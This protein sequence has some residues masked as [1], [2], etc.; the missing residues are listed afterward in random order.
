MHQI[1]IQ[2]QQRGPTIS[3]HLYGHFAEHLGRCVYGGFYV[4]EDSDIP[5]VRGIR[6]DIIE[7]LR[8]IR[9]PNLRWPGGCFADDYHWMD[10]IGPR[11]SRPR[12]VNAHWGGT[13]EDNAFGTH[14]FMDLC[15]LLGCEPYIAGNVGS[16]TVREMQQWIEYMTL[17][18]KSTM[19]ALRAENGRR[20]PWK[21][22]YFGIG[23]EN[24]GCGGNMRP[25]YYADLYRRY[26]TYVRN[27]SGN[28]IYRIACGPGEDNYEWTDV[29]M[30]MAGRHMDAL[31]LH[32]YTIPGPNWENKGSATA[33]SREEYLVTLARAMRMEE[34]IAANLQIM[35]RYDPEHRVAL[36]VDEWGAWY[37]VEPGTNPGFLY[38]QNTMRDAM[39][40][41]LTL[42]IFHRHADRVS[43]ANL[44]QTVNVLQA[45]LL[46]DGPRLVLTPTYHVFDLL[47]AHQDAALVGIDAPMEPMDG[48]QGVQRID[49]TASID[50]EGF[51]T[52]TLAN[53]DPDAAAEVAIRLDADPCGEATG[54][55]LAGDM[56]AYNDVG[57]PDRLRPATLTG[58]RR[59]GRSIRLTLPRCSVA[60]V[61]VPLEG[62]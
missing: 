57:A 24:W 11:E 31:T 9:I 12:T 15:E 55:V 4:G 18:G 53:C 30:R 44:A 2:T 62:H 16:G 34:M 58:M 25:E 37:D 5:N 39:V 3:R 21:L 14:E 36:I 29:L 59:E 41:V 23:N 47:K 61:R 1:S 28:E 22:R 13:I 49:A 60:A 52:L 10:G 40:A 17:G 19:A 6:S 50:A 54:R 42:H 7:A 26:Q 33:F 38:Q 8:H 32:H 43:M 46:T 20:E 48:A 27:F 35:D 45:P 51:L 56:A